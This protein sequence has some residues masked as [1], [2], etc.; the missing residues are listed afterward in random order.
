[1]R[2]L[3]AVLLLV[4]ALTGAFFLLQKTAAPTSCSLNVRVIDART[5]TPLSGATIVVA[6][7]G[8]RYPTGEGGSTGRIPIPFEPLAQAGETAVPWTEATVLAY[9]EGY[10]PYAL[11]HVC[12]SEGEARDNLTLYLFPNDGSMPDTPFVLV[13]APP[14]DWSR[15]LIERHRPG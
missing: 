13:E 9:C 11:L 15:A 4:S 10:Y 14:A 1:M 7:T 12:L 6:E 3:F 5:E 8:K 2:R